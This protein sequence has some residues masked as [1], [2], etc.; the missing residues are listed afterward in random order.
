MENLADSLGSAR[1]FW[2]NRL[3]RVLLVV[4]LSNLGSV[5]GTA[6]ALPWIAARI[7]LASG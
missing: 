6:V 5:L 4:V 1:G 2:S 7:A 3:T